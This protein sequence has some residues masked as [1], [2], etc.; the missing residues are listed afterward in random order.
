MNSSKRIFGLVLMILLVIS[1]FPLAA[2]AS[3]YGLVDSSSIWVYPTEFVPGGYGRLVMHTSEQGY[4]IRSYDDNPITQIFWAPVKLPSGVVIDDMVFYYYDRTGGPNMQINFLKH[5]TDNDNQV[6]LRRAES[7]STGGGYGSKSLV[8]SHKLTP[9]VYW[10]EVVF[11]NYNQYYLRV[12]MPYLSIEGFSD[13]AFKGV[14]IEYKRQA[15]DPPATATFSDVT[16]AMQFFPYV[17]AL[18]AAGITTGY[19]DGTFKPDDFVTRGQ[20]AAFLTRALGLHH[21]D[22]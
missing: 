8:V 10:D 5:Y 4:W 1:L 7:D 22:E 2:S 3:S 16:P 14:R 19:V 15:S 6:L 11:D 13:L 18:V 21:P 17:E 9:E 12:S 20:M